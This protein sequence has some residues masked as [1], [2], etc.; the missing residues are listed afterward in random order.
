[1]HTHPN[2]TNNEHIL[3]GYLKSGK[4]STHIIRELKYYRRR[5]TDMYG[6]V[7]MGNYDTSSRRDPFSVATTPEVFIQQTKY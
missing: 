5:M 7:V 1:M 4:L 6:D 3:R 2:H